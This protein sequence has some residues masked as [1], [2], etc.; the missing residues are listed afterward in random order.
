[1]SVPLDHARGSTHPFL[2]QTEIHIDENNNYYEVAI[3]AKPR[4][5]ADPPSLG[6]SSTSSGKTSDGNAAQA[7]DSAMV[8]IGQLQGGVEGPSKAEAGEA[9]QKAEISLND[10]LACRYVFPLPFS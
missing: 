2:I 10:C 1:M 8:G 9:L 4:T 6:F 7:L 5:A 3:A